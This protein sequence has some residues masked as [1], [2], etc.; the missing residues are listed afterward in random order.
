AGIDLG[1][2]NC[3]LAYV[4][5]ARGADAPVLDFPIPQLQRP[6][7]IV[8]RALLPS[9][10][11]LPAGQELPAGSTDL[12]WGPSAERV[13]GEFARWPDSLPKIHPCRGAPG[14][15][16]RVDRPPSPRSRRCPSG[17]LLGFSRGCRRRHI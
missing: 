15:F 4:E 17:D 14:R 9:S 6:G 1:T 10:I 3:A 13:I 12:P 11:Y 7:E 16:L 8:P 5:L 2:S